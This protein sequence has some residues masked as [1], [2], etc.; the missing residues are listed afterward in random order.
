MAAG[1]DAATTVRFVL[2]AWQGA[3]VGARSDRTSESFDAF[4]DIVFG[5]LL[6]QPR[7]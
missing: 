7:P 3:I 4:F 6:A 5:T 2:N 1:L